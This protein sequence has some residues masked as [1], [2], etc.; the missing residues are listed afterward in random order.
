MNPPF[1]QRAA[2]S[3]FGGKISPPRLRRVV[4]ND[5]FCFRALKCQIEV[6]VQ[7]LPD[8]IVGAIEL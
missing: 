6:K 2:E 5:V 1:R 3:C 7:F 8:L 4:R